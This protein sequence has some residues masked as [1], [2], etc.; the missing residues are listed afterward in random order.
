MLKEVQFLQN[1][2]AF[3]FSLVLSWYAHIF[4]I[5]VLIFLN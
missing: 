4:Y 2:S 3:G 1:D 5:N